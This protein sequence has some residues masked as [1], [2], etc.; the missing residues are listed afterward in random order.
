M[1]RLSDLLKVTVSGRVKMQIQGSRAQA[2]HQQTILSFSGY[3]L[4]R[5]SINTASSIWHQK[6]Y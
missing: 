4:S 1:D 2:L 5:H 6:L 3:C